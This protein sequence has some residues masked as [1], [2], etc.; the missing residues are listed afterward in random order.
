MNWKRGYPLLLVLFLAV[1]GLNA[2][3]TIPTGPSV[4]VLPGQGKPFE[5]F[6]AD[7]V[8]CRQWA[9]QQ[10]GAE[11]ADNINRNLAA[12]AVLGTLAGAALGAAIGSGSG[13]AGTGAAIGAASGLIGGTAVASGPAYESGYQL[14]R[15]YDHAYQQCMYSK[16]NEIPGF[17]RPSRR[18]APPPPPPP[19]GYNPGQSVPPPSGSYPPQPSPRY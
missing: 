4:M 9:R 13:D 17:S 5:A 15:R 14:Q 16:G 11:P 3:A 2:C 7:D 18:S 10:I 19:P 1:A 8:V 6:Q 12:G